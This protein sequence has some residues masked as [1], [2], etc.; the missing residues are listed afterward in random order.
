MHG[1]GTFRGGNGQTYK[2]DFVA[3]K[4]NGQ[5]KL[6]KK[7]GTLVYNGAWLNDEPDNRE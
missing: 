5:G 3:D 4:R 2:G 1:K 6:T 7:D